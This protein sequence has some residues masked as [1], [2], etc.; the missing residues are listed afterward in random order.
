MTK[1][2]VNAERKQRGKPFAPGV[3][4][5]PS[6]K[7]LG[8][9]HKATV[10]VE[11]LMEGDAQA[12]ARKAVEL[13]LGGD[14]VALR[15]CLER[16]A[17]VRKGRPLVLRLPTVK[18]SADIVK[19]LSAVVGHVAAGDLTIEEAAGVAALLEAK[20]KAI[21]MV[22]IEARVAKLEQRGL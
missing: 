5:N 4:G 18:T 16:I 19:A 13:A 8:A 22:E 11:S 2:A 1:G 6:G 9:R 3:S 20:R 12:L 7:P 17:P 10:A 15:L 14:T 21:E